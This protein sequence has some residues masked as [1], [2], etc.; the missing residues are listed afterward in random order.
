MPQ[1]QQTGTLSQLPDSL[2]QE[3]ETW[4]TRHS[5][6]VQEFVLQTLH[7]KL[8]QLQQFTDD[9]AFPQITYRQGASGR[10]QP[11]IKGTRLRV[12]TVVIEVQQ[13][14]SPRQIADEFDVTETQVREALA[15]YAAH[16]AQIQATMSAELAMEAEQL[17]CPNPVYIE[18]PMLLEKLYTKL[19]YKKVMMLL[20]LPTNGCLR[21]QVM[22]LS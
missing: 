14:E 1:I 5:M 11:V 20:V 22:R 3:I 21:M 16:T 19:C 2:Y 17:S 9:P 12:Q 8:H 7:D 18:M 15:F 6:T 4:A 10:L 13:G